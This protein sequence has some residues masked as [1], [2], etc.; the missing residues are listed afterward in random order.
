[1]DPTG[2]YKKTY[3]LFGAGSKAGAL[4]VAA[5]GTATGGGADVAGS[6]PGS[7]SLV[8]SAG[9]AVSGVVAAGIVGAGAVAAA[10]A[11]VVLA[12]AGVETGAVVTAGFNKS[13]ANSALTCSGVRV[14]WKNIKSSI[15]PLGAMDG[16]APPKT[17]AI[18]A[19]IGRFIVSSLG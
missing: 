18:A 3:G 8:D 9:S 2:F 6:L 10:G 12:G 14:I 11:S 7:V 17:R 15:M 5:A 19:S 1:M 4:D 13:P 16:A